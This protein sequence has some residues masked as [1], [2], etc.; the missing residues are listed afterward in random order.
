M[1]NEAL[2]AKQVEHA[3]PAPNKRIEIPA[4]PPKGL[5]L[6]VQSSGSKSWAFRYRWLGKSR[7]LTFPKPY[8]KMKLA[9]AR[10][11]AQAKVDELEAGNDPARIQEQE[12]EAQE[13]SKESFKSVVDEYVKRE[14]CIDPENPERWKRE[15]ARILNQTVKEWKHRMISDIAKP[16]V[17]RLLDAIV[18]RGASVMACRTRGA[19]LRFFSWT[20]GRGYIE[21]S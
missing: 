1:K 2:T 9:A 10:A 21:A 12:I 15:I 7:K 8:P 14:L 17:L 20:K 19:L 3:K 4:G 5:Y 16:D 13:L 6:V 18:D 11:E